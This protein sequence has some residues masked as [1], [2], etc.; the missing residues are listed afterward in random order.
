[1]NNREQSRREKE[2]EKEKIKNLETD[3]SLSPPYQA[4]G[5]E[6][7]RDPQADWLELVE[8]KK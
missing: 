7:S 1:M 6:D 2:R 5:P 3:R 8:G 4:E